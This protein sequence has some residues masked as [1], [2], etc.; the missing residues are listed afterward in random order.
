MGTK[1]S[2]LVF[3]CFFSCSN[4]LSAQSLAEIAAKERERRGANKHKQAKSF[5]Y[6]ELTHSYGVKAVTKSQANVEVTEDVEEVGEQVL[7]G[8]SSTDERNTPEYWRQRVED[9]NDAI[10]RFENALDSEDWGNG[11][12]IGVDPRGQN[13]L[14]RR[15]NLQRQLQ[16]AKEDLLSLRNEA[17]LAGIPPGWIR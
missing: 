9:L 6:F 2:M 16:A 17:R 14:N 13:N 5:S 3:F 4:L 11:Q 1:K 12:R 7:V 10:L 8:P 15:E